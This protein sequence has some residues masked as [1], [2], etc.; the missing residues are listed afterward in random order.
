MCGIAGFIKR[1]VAGSSQA[2]L[3]AMTDALVH[4]GP[5]ASGYWYEE[6]CG[7]GL[8]HRRLSI[9]DLSESGQQPM[10]SHSGRYTIVFNGEVYNFE[11]LRK[12]LVAHG[13]VFRSHSDTE[14]ILAAFDQW[15]ID[16]SLPKFIG[17]FAFAVWDAQERQLVLARDR[18]GKKPLY[19]GFVGGGFVFGSELRALLEFPGWQPTVNRPALTLYM[20]HNCVPAP[21]SIYEGVNKLPA[22][23][24]VRVGVRSDGPCQLSLDSYWSAAQQQASAISAPFRGSLE[25]ATDELDGLLGDA[26]G[27]RMVSDV[28]LGAFLSGGIDSSLIVSLMQAQAKA[29]VRTFT[30]GFNERGY[31]EA[32]QAKAV[33][34][35]LGTDHTELYVSPGDALAVIPKLPGIYD[36]PFSDSSQI[37]TYLVCQMARR[38]VTVALSGDGGDEGFCGYNRY[39]WWR[40]IW[41]KTSHLPQWLLQLSARGIQSISAETLD[42]VMTAIYPLLPQSLRVSAPGDRL[43]RLAAVLAIH[44]PQALYRQLVSHWSAPQQVVLNAEEPTTILNETVQLDGNDDFL[45]RMMLLDTLTYLPDDILTKVDRASM[46]VGLEVRA[47]LLDHRVIE[48]AW[49]LPL[50]MKLRGRNG[51]AVLKN[52]LYRYMPRELVDRPKTGFGVPLDYWLRGPL[53]DWAESLLAPER[54]R[55]EGYFAV[56]PIQKAWR[57]HLSGKRQWHYHIWDVLMFQA[58]LNEPRRISTVS[59]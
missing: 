34:R 16:A 13:H 32:A 1:G 30:I 42:K 4:R 31:D 43:H 35:H 6:G 27:L 33:V 47:P 48:F 21:W 59:G 50:E 36:E 55:R 22:A 9:L 24:I 17:M 18:L 15:G 3:R 8:G 20:R 56:E 26:V 19:Y 53:R 45:N 37:P 41:G 28:A 52:L 11:R 25:E 49:S 54:L 5:D 38:N 7:V 40:K 29:P 2:V 46:A 12:T 57:E 14:V 23:H 44:D 51:K 39:V 10:Q 58:W